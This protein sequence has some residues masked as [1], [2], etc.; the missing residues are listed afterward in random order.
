MD[1]IKQS[2]K[3]L[4][5]P[6]VKKTKEFLAKNANKVI[7]EVTLGQLYGGM[8]GVK[9]LTT[10]TSL[11]DA[12]N[13]ISFRGFSIKEIVTK[14]QSLNLKSKQPTP[15]IL[16]ILFLLGH[17]PTNDE[18][19]NLSEEWHKRA[20]VPGYAFDI[21]N[22]LPKNIH[23]MA[24]FTTVISALQN[25]SI[26]NKAYHD[27]M[28][29]DQYWEYAYED[30][31]NIISMLPSI[32]AYI[33]NY[34]YKDNKQKDP[35]ESLDWAG[36]LAYMISDEDNT[37]DSTLK[38]YM[39]LYMFLH[40]DH[41]G[42]NASAFTCH[43]VGATLA[44]PYAAYAS[45]MHSLSGPLHGLAC[46][47][48]LEFIQGMINNYGKAPTENQIKDYI[49]SILESGK[50][51]PGYGHAV[52]RTTDPRFIAQMEFA[53]QYNLH[54]DAID[55]VWRTYEIAPEI[56]KKHAPKIKNP[57]PNIDNHT[58]AVLTYFNFKNPEFY[59]VLFGAAR[60]IGVL[61]SLVWSRAMG[62]PIYRP[63][64]I[65]TDWLLNNIK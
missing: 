22:K 21:I 28:T 36:N 34:N 13:G 15:E 31:M 41:E 35:D 61:S 37:F 59:T 4:A 44:S 29:K 49:V 1:S 56:L 46:Q 39:R 11:L 58:G 40:S 54:S 55:T 48:S 38:E 14:V 24:Q 17:I 23:P 7:D 53:K 51:I 2:F 33:Y 43:V 30:A 3:S 32:V 57:Y 50:V 65:T 25:E 10:E 26:F 9:S 60:A 5:I 12:E 63:K 27:S 62:L 42:G 19:E 45:S 8:R 47:T 6:Y 18:I 20:N 16:F 52:L 64:S